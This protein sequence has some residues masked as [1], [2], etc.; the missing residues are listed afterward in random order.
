[1]KKQNPTPGRERGFAVQALEILDSLTVF[2]VLQACAVK[3]WFLNA[4]I[5]WTSTWGM[6]LSRWTD[7][8]QVA[9]D[10]AGGLE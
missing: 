5:T 6:R 3:L 10:N 4:A 2:L 7:R 9:I 8:L 1:M